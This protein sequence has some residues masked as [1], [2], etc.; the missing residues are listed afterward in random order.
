MPI[1]RKANLRDRFIALGVS[2]NLAAD[3]A[4]TVSRFVRDNGPEWTVKRLKLIRVAFLKRIAGQSYTLPYV[5]TRQDAQGAV[6][7]GSFGTLW[8]QAST[9][10]T[11]ISRVLN[12]LMV[13]ST[14]Y[15]EQ[16]TETQW[17]KFHSS[18]TRVPSDP[19]DVMSVTGQIRVPK[20]ARVDR[21]KGLTSFEEFVVTH[22]LSNKVVSDQV[23]SFV[24]TDTGMAL[25]EEFPQ[26][27]QSL[28]SEIS[29]SIDTRIRFDD[30][31]GYHDPLDSSKTTAPIGK[32]G[33]SQEAGY[34][35]R[36]FA[37]PNIVHQVAM[38]RLKAQLF[39][40]LAKLDW[41]CTY[42]QSSGTDW[43]REQLN[44][45]KELFSIDLS[46]A[47]NNFPLS[48]QLHVLRKIGCLEEDVKLF[49]RLSRAPWGAFFR[50]KWVGRWSVGQ[51]LGLGPSFAAFAL[52]HG[53][54]VNSIAMDIGSK[55]AFRVLGDDIV[56]AG[57]ELASKYLQAMQKL[58]V[59]ISE[60]KTIRSDILAEFAGKCVTKDGILASLKWKD[61]SDR[62]FLDV[63]RLL[64]P[65]SFPLL[66]E[67]QRK[68]ASFVSV[69]PEPLGFGWNPYGISL[70]DRLH[71]LELV[72]QLQDEPERSYFPIQ[73]SWNK[74]RMNLK[75]SYLRVRFTPTFVGDPDPGAAKASEHYSRLP[76]PVGGLEHQLSISEMT[77]CPVRL[78]ES[79]LT[80]HIT[81][82]LRDL[83]FATASSSSDPR[84]MNPLEAWER[85]I[86]KL[87][88][89]IGQLALNG[90]VSQ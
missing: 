5:A 90:L 4:S 56:I 83:G 66:T 89:V 47:T 87:R 31:F 57:E 75:Q 18:M 9:D 68:V 32:L 61:P 76:R 40:L 24:E 72:E 69:L 45:G 14:F 64:G 34:K 43:A 17:E 16:V 2:R 19:D 60:D 12:A 42:N 84:G 62:S 37:A 58:G 70:Q 20:W 53:I 38:S 22:N 41:D 35:L 30:Y 44:Q 73:R 13:Y 59:P 88:P 7:K 86:A 85:K 28:K 39:G 1:R 74:H 78:A 52:T 63:V 82:R 77:G 33:C 48:V 15:A 3:L 67:R 23:D 54:L 55:D 36:V 25:W 6:P 10:I 21:N 51:P 26:Y 29:N 80:P 49:H 46:D 81:K 71:L 65:R 11:S 50:V 8:K 27:K 79:Q